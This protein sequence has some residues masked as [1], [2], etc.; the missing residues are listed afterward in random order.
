ME[1]EIFIKRATFNCVNPF[2]KCD[3]QMN[4]YYF[5]ADARIYECDRCAAKLEVKIKEL[6]GI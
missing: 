3:G 5:K 6:R 2:E 1:N 4:I